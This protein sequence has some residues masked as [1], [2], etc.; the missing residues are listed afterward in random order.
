MDN[1]RDVEDGLRIYTEED[2]GML[3]SFS[4][5]RLTQ[6]AEKVFLV[7]LGI[8]YFGYYHKNPSSTHGHP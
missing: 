8:N 7:H 1:R 2:M 6:W 3:D 4:V 5:V